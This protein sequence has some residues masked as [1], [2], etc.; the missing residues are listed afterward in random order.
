[1]E[2]KEKL[3]NLEEQNN[4][5]IKIQEQTNERIRDVDNDKSHYENK[6]KELERKYRE[7]KIKNA[8]LTRRINALEMEKVEL[9]Q[10][11]ENATEFFN[12]LED[13]N[14]KLE[15]KN[16]HDKRYIDDL[17]REIYEGE[18]HFEAIVEIN[19]E[20]MKEPRISKK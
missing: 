6:I 13:I 7:E 9:K 17:N 12:V 2:I 15:N 1:M 14:E 3:K 18:E 16:E 11:L 5:K 4:E 19:D 8:G 10:E 20:L